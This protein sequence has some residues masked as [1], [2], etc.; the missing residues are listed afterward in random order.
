MIYRVEHRRDGAIA[1]CV[2]VESQHKNGGLVFYIEAANREEAI[3]KSKDKFD[4]FCKRQAEKRAASTLCGWCRIEPRARKADGSLRPLCR[5]CQVLA[6]SSSQKRH[7]LERDISRLPSAERIKAL[8]EADEETRKKRRE[9]W[10]TKTHSKAVAAT[11]RKANDRWDSPGFVA[12]NRGG[13]T[14]LRQCLRVYD[15]DPERFRQWLIS[16]LGQGQEAQAAE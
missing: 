13:I 6:N 2:E 10:M 1:S 9:L 3:A 15:R 5:G 8:A 7:K 12:K 4:R 16:V 14:A 11:V